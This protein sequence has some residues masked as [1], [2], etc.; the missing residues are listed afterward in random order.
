MTFRVEPL[1]DHSLHDF[2]SGNASLDEWLALHART[3]IGHGSRTYVLLDEGERVVGYFTLTP[4]LLARDDAPRRLAR[5]A[6]LRIPSILLAKLA[7]DASLQGRGLGSDLLVHA[8]T[9]AVSGARRV[10][11][12]LL[13]VDAI[14][15]AAR[16]FYEHHSFTALPRRPDRL[17]IKLSTAAA[18]LKLEWP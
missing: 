14:D 1:S 9:V 17:V 15:D 4:H 2:R 10:G 3:A 6:P 12:R 16:S 7:L 13:L 11:G 5:G 8:T 18:A